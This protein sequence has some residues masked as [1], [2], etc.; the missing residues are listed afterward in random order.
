MAGVISRCV[1]VDALP[2]SVRALSSLR[3]I[4]YADYFTLSLKPHA[5]SAASAAENATPERWAG[6]MFGGSEPNATQQ[7]IWGFLLGF[8]LVRSG[9]G[10]ARGPSAVAGT[11]VVAGW[12]VDGRGADWVRLR[13]QSWFLTGNLVVVRTAADGDRMV[14]ALATFSQYDRWWGRVWWPVLTP[15]HRALV[16]MVLKGGAARMR[17]RM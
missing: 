12:R 6:T 8:Q 2:S 4:D 5:A 14:V 13:A 10:R 15:L 11:A 3:S 1:G 7:F 9:G 16:P 17:A